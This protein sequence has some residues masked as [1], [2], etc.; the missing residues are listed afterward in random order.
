MPLQVLRVCVCLYT[1]GCVLVSMT[2]QV[3]ISIFLASSGLTPGSSK[4]AAGNKEKGD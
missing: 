1:C 2:L 4:Q 3:L